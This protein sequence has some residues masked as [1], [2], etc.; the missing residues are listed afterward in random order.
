MVEYR[1]GGQ[2]R[3]GAVSPVATEFTVVDVETANQSRASICQVGIVQVRGGEIR[4]EWESLVNPEGEFAW[5]CQRVH[6]IKASAVA[7][8]PRFPQIYPQIRELL[9]GAVTVSHSDFDRQAIEQSVTRYDLPGLNSRWVDSASVARKAWPDRAGQDGYG[10][11]ELA[12]FLGIRFEHHDA[13]EDARA[14]AR[15]TL[16]ACR[17]CGCGL[18]ELSREFQSAKGRERRNSD[19]ADLI[20]PPV[21]SGHEFADM[22]NGSGE[23][24]VV[25]TGKLSTGRR[26]AKERAIGAGC[27]VHDN[28]TKQTTALVVGMQSTNALKG[29]EK[30]TKQRKAEAL[31]AQGSNVA[32][33]GERDFWGLIDQWGA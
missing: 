1:S 11:H 23:V 28:V 6:G 15:I 29:Q 31:A 14:A 12:Q 25:F 7:E 32:I 24:I 17:A 19:P 18:D 20:Q 2:S 8:S 30:S 9:A 5:F 22:L 21:G 26:A 16:A 27:T 4:N 10:L 33:L 13:L 3:E